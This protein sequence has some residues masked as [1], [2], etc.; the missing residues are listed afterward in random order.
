MQEGSARICLLTETMTITRQRV[1][2]SI[3]KKRLGETS[4]YQ[5]A[6]TKFYDQILQVKFFFL[7]T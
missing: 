2:V 3:P 7:F 5:K 4:Q 1:E 6:V